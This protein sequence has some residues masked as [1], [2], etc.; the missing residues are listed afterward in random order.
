MDDDDY[1]DDRPEGPAEEDVKV[2]AVPASHPAFV[3]PQLPQLCKALPYQQ[4][5]V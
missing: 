5:V 4:A 3:L 2:C 1:A